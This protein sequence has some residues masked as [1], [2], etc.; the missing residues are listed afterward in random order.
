MMT[1]KDSIVIA[2]FANTTGDPVFD[3]TL[4]QGLSAQLSQTPFLD[5]ISGD[6]IAQ[7]LRLMEKAPERAITPDVAR[8]VCQRLNATTAIDGSIAALGS[9]YVIGLD[10]VNCRN[11]RDARAGA[12]DRRQQGKGA[13]SARRRRVPVARE[14]RRV[15]Q[16]DDGV[17]RAARS[18][19]HV[20]AR[21]AASLCARQSGR[22]T[23][24][25]TTR[26]RSPSSKRPSRSIRISRWRTCGWPKA[27]SR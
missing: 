7:T 5:I 13:R 18:G 23:S 6:Q 14:A 2:D 21:G 12:T 16:V 4:R 27:T 22:R 26:R 24:R 8:E 20:V 9:Q 15:A 17:Q 11:R 1:E 10:A 25:T 3:N 19:D